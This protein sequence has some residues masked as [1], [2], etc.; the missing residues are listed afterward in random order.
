M[1]SLIFLF[2]IFF[3]FFSSRRRHTRFKCDWSSDVCSSDLAAIS[4]KKKSFIPFFALYLERAVFLQF[5]RPRR[6]HTTGIPPEFYHPPLTPPRKDV[7]D[8]PVQPV[9]TFLAAR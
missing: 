8:D 4:R 1:I 3:F 2:Y 7:I 6:F 9:S 5:L